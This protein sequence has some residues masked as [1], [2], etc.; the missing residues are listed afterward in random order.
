MPVMKILFVEEGPVGNDVFWCG[1]CCCGPPRLSEGELR[2]RLQEIADAKSAQLLQQFSLIA[3]QVGLSKNSVLGF[4]NP[5]FPVVTRD[6]VLV[7]YNRLISESRN[8]VHPFYDL[9]C[10]FVNDLVA[11]F[12]KQLQHILAKLILIALRVTLR[13]SLRVKSTFTPVELIPHSI[14]P[15]EASA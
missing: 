6:L 4:G 9:V 13:R 2:A 10:K 14:H 1:S 5:R 15:I 12:K 7:L 3:R 8:L 11:E